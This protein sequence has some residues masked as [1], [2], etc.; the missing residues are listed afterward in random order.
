MTCWERLVR[1]SYMVSR[2]PSS[3]S[4]GVEGLGD[5]VEGG[6][7]LGDAFEGEVLG[8]HGDE[9][10]VGGDEGVEGEEIERRRAVEQDEGV[11]GADGLEGLAEAELAALPGLTSSML[12][13]MRFLLPGTRERLAIS[14]GWMTSAAGVAADEEV[15]D[16]GAVLVAAEA[17]A[18]GGVGLGVAVDEEG[19]R[20]SRARAAARLMAVVVLPTPPFWL[21]MARILA[22]GATGGTG[23]GLFAG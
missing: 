2:T 13:P 12:A 6:H 17:E 20:P 16:R 3:A 22:G 1:S 8:L 7:E 9:E 10:A 4:A 19:W 5:A 11:V 18:A 21:T 23:L 15:V 14:V